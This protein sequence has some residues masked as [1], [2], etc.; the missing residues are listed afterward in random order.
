MIRGGSGTLA[1]LT[2]VT[3]IRLP[4]SLLLPTPEQ[5]DPSDVLL[6][7]RAFNNTTVPLSSRH[8]SIIDRMIGSKTS[9]FNSSC[10][11]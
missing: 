1:M 2:L 6:A 4:F 10:R 8:D 3:V 9:H 7:F 5:V 11:N